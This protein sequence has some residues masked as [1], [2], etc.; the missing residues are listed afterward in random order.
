M[1]NLVEAHLT[2]SDFLSKTTV[3]LHLK[4][5][6]GFPD[7]YGA[8]LSALAD[9]LAEATSPL[10]ISI[11]IAP[12]ELPEGMQAYALRLVQV[13][14]REA[15]ANENVSLIVEHASRR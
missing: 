7:Y 13:C 9:C 11:D 4:R 12:E 15:L 3:H 14:A 10:L 6:L 8:N 2:A 1:S 5:Q